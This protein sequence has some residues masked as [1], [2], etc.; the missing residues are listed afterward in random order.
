MFH[1]IFA[2]GCGSNKSQ[3]STV[4]LETA[5]TTLHG[6]EFRKDS[7]TYYISI[8]VAFLILAGHTFSRLLLPHP[9]VAHLFAK[10]TSYLQGFELT[11]YVRKKSVLF[12]ALPFG[13]K[14][15]Y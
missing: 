15:L 5:R 9:K 3:Q 2:D 1:S 7:Y 8:Y 6:F 14:L 11:E 13:M 10:I 12:H 4:F